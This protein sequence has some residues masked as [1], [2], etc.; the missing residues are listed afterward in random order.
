MLVRIQKITCAQLVPFSNGRREGANPSSR[1]IVL[2]SLESQTFVV[3]Q[4]CCFKLGISIPS[5]RTCIPGDRSHPYRKDRW[6]LHFIFVVFQVVAGNR[7]DSL[8]TPLGN[9]RVRPILS[10]MLSSMLFRMLNLSIFDFC[11]IFVA[12][13]IYVLIIV[14]LSTSFLVNKR[15][16]S[17][18]THSCAFTQHKLY[19]RVS[20]FQEKVLATLS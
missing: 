18:R 5:L 1:V 7:Y 16:S 6:R 19:T 17:L 8:A 4:L 14:V 10:H 9:Q 12:S 20:F 2:S 11:D 13:F 15:Q 3:D